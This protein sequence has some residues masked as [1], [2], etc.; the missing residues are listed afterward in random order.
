MLFGRR[1]YE[2]FES[3][4]PEAITDPRGA[5][6]PH[7]RGNRS[8]AT[9]NVRQW[10]DSARKI[11]FS[12]RRET[13]T[14]W[15]SEMIGCRNG[16]NRALLRQLACGDRAF[17]AIAPLDEEAC[18]LA[19]HPTLDERTQNSAKIVDRGAIDVDEIAL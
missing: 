8:E 7:V 17:Y 9:R 2:M 18:G 3:F 19:F 10:I 16:A 6:D 5:E 1:T 12:R 13:V 14:W 11:V 4:W 15:G